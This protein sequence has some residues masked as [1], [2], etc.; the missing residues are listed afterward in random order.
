MHLLVDADLIAYEAAA[1]ADTVDEGMERRS[2]DWVM[3]KVDSLITHIC[4]ECGVD[5]PHS[6]F[7]TGKDNFRF[8]IAT[9]KPYKGNRQ[10]EKPFY[11]ESTRKYLQVRH[12]AIMVNGMEADDALAITAKKLGYEN[13]IIA[14]RDKDLKQVPCTHFSWECYNQP[15]WGP[16]LVTEIGDIEIE[17]ED[18][19]LKSG[20][21][22][23]AVKKISGTGLKWFYTQ[24]ITGD[25]TDNIPGLE[26]KGAALAYELLKD[27]TTEIEMF[28]RVMQAYTEKYAENAAERLLEQGRLLWMCRDKIKGKAVMWEF[29]VCQTT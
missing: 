3:E 12:N 5:S 21:P 14:S 9:V 1:G 27:T 15:Q 20:L 28:Q 6:I 19:L 13:T 18:K 16:E 24:C 8:D 26:G 23:K 11:L 25:S 7:L 17:L 22:S 10:T 29:P 2:F 4:E